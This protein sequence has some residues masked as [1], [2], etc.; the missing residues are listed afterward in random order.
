[1]A[2]SNRL[3]ACI[4]A[5]GALLLTAPA[6]ADQ[7]D[8]EKWSRKI[9]KYPVPGD[10]S[11]DKAK[12]FCVCQDTAFPWVGY[13]ISRINVDAGTETSFFSCVAPRFDEATG[14]FD[15]LRTCTSFEMLPK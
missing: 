1:M 10:T 13:L 11:W 2:N 14:E 8:Q 9:D 6:H 12:Y 15:S 4:L 5:L 3:S 7:T